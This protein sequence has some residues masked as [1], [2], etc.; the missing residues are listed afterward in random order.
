MAGAASVRAATGLLRLSNALELI[1]ASHTDPTLTLKG[2]ADR[3][4]I[5]PAHFSRRFKQ[6]TGM[7][8]T[9]YVRALRVATAKRLL[10]T[11]TLSVKEVAAAV[12]YS[13]PNLLDRNFRLVCRVTPTGFRADHV[14]RH[15]SSIDRKYPPLFPLAGEDITS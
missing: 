5:S 1:H 12:G 6:R 9:S 11:T 13:S 2:I 8:F 14:A 7:G 3:C 10:A 15:T 4:D